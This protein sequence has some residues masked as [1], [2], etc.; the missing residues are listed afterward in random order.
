[1]GNRNLVTKIWEKIANI[2]AEKKDLL[3]LLGKQISPTAYKGY[4]ENLPSSK[5]VYD[6]VPYTI[7][8]AMEED[9]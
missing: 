4:Y 6:I 8:D 3:Y 2:R 5:K 7:P 9:D 1:M